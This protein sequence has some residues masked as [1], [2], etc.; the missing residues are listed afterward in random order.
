M[1]DVIDFLTLYTRCVQEFNIDLHELAT[2]PYA[3]GGTLSK[4][5][6]DPF[7]FSNP[8]MKSYSV[9]KYSVATQHGDA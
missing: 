8:W 1:H 3:D 7:L 5:K 6:G 4:S 9:F 2:K